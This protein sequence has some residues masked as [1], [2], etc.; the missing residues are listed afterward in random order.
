MFTNPSYSKLRVTW[1]LL[2]WILL[3]LSQLR[4]GVSV[5]DACL[6]WETTEHLL[7]LAAERLREA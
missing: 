3:Q 5:T 7:S 2:G 4:H 1:Y 6:G